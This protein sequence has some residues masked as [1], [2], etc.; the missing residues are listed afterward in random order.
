MKIDAEKEGATLA[1]RYNVHGYPTIFF[2]RANGK[3]VERII[4]YLPPAEFLA[5]LGRIKRGEDTYESLYLGSEKDPADFDLALKLATK[6]DDRADYREAVTVWTRVQGLAKPASE[7]AMLSTFK[8]AES[9]ARSANEPALLVEYL[10][11]AGST[12]YHI[13][14]YQ[15][16]VRIYRQ[17]K[18]TKSEAKNFVAL[19]DHATG[20]QELTSGMLNGYAWRMTQLELNLEDA[21]EKIALA[22]ELAGTDDGANRAELLD[23]QAE[24]LWKLGRN[25]QAIEIMNTCLELVPDSQYFMDQKAK[26]E[27][28]KTPA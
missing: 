18:D 9:T 3:E 4:G 25:D 26:F 15:A 13:E 17:N 8:I 14:A 23:T 27:S 12:V 5:E 22:V 19:I 7:S 21:L 28:A 1:K 2:V 10:A 11:N 16:L 24:V 20:M 6:L